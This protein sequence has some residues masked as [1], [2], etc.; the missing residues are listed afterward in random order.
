MDRT[1]EDIRREL[2]EQCG[3]IARFAGF[4]V[5]STDKALDPQ[6]GYLDWHG[7]PEVIGI[8]RAGNLAGVL[9]DPETAVL[10]DIAND[11]IIDTGNSFN[12]AF[13]NSLRQTKNPERDAEIMALYQKLVCEM[14]KQYTKIAG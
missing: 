6:P 4:C 3:N 8:D 1:P 11:S 10:I 12:I 2:Y 5:S 14:L 9:I 7:Q 13:V